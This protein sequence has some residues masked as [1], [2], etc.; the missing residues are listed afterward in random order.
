MDSPDGR[1]QSGSTQ[2]PQLIRQAGMDRFLT[3]KLSWNKFTAPPHHS[4]HWRGLDGSSVLTHFPPVDTYNAVATMEELR[5][6]AANYKDADRTTEAVYLFG[7]GDGGGGPNAT[8]VENLRRA[9]DLLG[10]PRSETRSPDDFFDRLAADA[11]QLATIQGE[12]YFEYHRGTYTSQA[13]IKRLNRLCEGRLQDLEFA[14]TACGLA[15]APAPSRADVEQLWRVLLVNQFHDIL[16]GSSIAEVYARSRPELAELADAAARETRTCLDGLAH[17]AA[18]DWQPINSIGFPRAGLAEDPDGALHHV[19]AEPFAA[20]RIAEAA[21]RVTLTELPGGE[22]RLQNGQL[23]AILTPTGAV[24]S[25][26]HK[27]TGREALAEPANRFVLYD[28]RPTL[29]EAWD[30]DPFALETGREAAGAHR[31]E[32]TERGPLRA[33]VRYEHRIGKASAL[34]QTIRLDAASGRIDFD[35]TIDWRERRTLLKAAFPLAALSMRA[36]YE[37]MFGAVERPTHANTDADLAQYEVPGHRWADLSEPGFGVSLLTDSRYGYATFGQ[38]MS[39][40]LLRGTAS[41]DRHA[42]LGTHRLAYALFP[43]AG[44]WRDAGTVGEAAR[45]NRPVLWTRGECAGVLARPLVAAE[46]ANVV[47][48]TLKPAEDGDGWVVRLYEAHGAT[49]TAMLRFGPAIQGVWVSDTLEDRGAAIDVVDGECE[50]ALTPWRILT[51][52]VR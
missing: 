47:I 27:A 34:T 16:P 36:T 11:D 45:F 5:Y 39:L 41:P 37:T 32:I 3:Q 51:L 2:L 21:D 9:G 10:V 31:C 49:T 13:E 22:I 35:T 33:A 38:V 50:L 19:A 6:H 44:D 42:D 1:L 18:G 48:D 30:I 12:L 23:A 4:F 24:R 40:S 17:E 14:A 43:H 8:M 7:H 15:S 20:G 52:R 25:L 26:V 46:P 29:F 28:D